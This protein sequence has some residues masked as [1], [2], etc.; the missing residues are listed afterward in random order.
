MKCIILMNGNSYIMAVKNRIAFSSANLKCACGAIRE[1]TNIVWLAVF[2]V[3]LQLV[4]MAIWALGTIG[5]YQILRQEDPDCKQLEQRGRVCGGN[6]LG[7][8]IF[9]VLLSLYWGQQVLVNVLACTTSGTVA[10]WWYGK[11]GDGIVGGAFKRS[12]TTSFGS[13][14]FGSLLVAVV[15]ALRTVRFLR[16]MYG[17]VQVCIVCS[18]VA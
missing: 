7:V 11:Q 6:W 2:M 15:S 10:S 5:V 3:V 8:S 1:Y 16:Y 13:I 18:N 9:G 14:C 4:W 17:L 12:M